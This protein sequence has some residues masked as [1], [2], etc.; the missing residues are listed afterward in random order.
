[1]PW[2]IGVP[3]YPQPQ[4]PLTAIGLL[5][6]AVKLELGIVQI[7]DNLPLDQMSDAS[8]DELRAAAHT[9]GITLEAGTRGVEPSHLLR[10]IAIAQRIG[11]TIIRTLSHTAELKPDIGQ[12]ETWIRQVLPTLEEAGVTLALENNEA[13]SVSEYAWLMRRIAS[14]YVGICMD[15]AN[16]LGRPEVL[17]AVVEELA[18][19]AV[20]LHVKDFD[21]HRIDTRMGFSVVGCPAGEGKVDFDLVFDQLALRGRD[22]SVILEHWP[23]FAGTIENTVRLEE[24]WV[25]RSIRFLKARASVPA[26]VA[27]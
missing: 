5:D 23:P 2:A 19:F 22:P 12:V 13:H 14:P 20:V 16:S 25:A 7:A 17:K 1:V 9:R 21:I 24:E 15:T 8:L 18:Q 4:H 10:Y 27:R 6:L 3:G 11:A 26:L